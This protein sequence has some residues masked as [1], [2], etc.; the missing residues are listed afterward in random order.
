MQRP[1]D[2]ERRESCWFFFLSKQD[3]IPDGSLLLYVLV[4]CCLT[5]HIVNV[6]PCT[7]CKHFDFPHSSE[8][9]I[10][11][12]QFLLGVFVMFNWNVKE[13]LT[14]CKAKIFFSPK[15]SIFNMLKLKFHLKLITCCWNIF[16][17]LQYNLIVCNFHVNCFSIS[18]L[19]WIWFNSVV[20]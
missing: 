20:L 7:L 18:V 13:L 15:L 10:W 2:Q 6:H 9:R 12:L 16:G 11:E 14:Q 3:E 4:C 5:Y 19:N 8:Y 1:A 17:K